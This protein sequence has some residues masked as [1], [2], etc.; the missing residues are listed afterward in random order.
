MVLDIKGLEV[1]GTNSVD[2]RIPM[3]VL[4]STR[5]PWNQYNKIF[6]EKK[7]HASFNL[8]YIVGFEAQNCAI[9]SWIS[10][11]AIF[12]TT[13]MAVITTFLVKNRWV[14]TFRP[15]GINS[16]PSPWVFLGRV[17]VRESSKRGRC[18]HLFAFVKTVSGGTARN[19]VMALWPGLALWPLLLC[20]GWPIFLN[21]QQ[22]T[23][24]N[25]CNCC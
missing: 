10:C 16:N 23:L 21:G 15:N 17:N 8:S 25:Q 18:F 12:M 9:K 14:K 1:P 7:T 6:L 19:S 24:Q 11:L 4:D 22:S 5:T 13:N 3:R 2:E 20:C